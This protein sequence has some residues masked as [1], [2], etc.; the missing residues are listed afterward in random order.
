[1]DE[2]FTI[3]IIDNNEFRKVTDWAKLE[4]FAPGYDDISIFKNTDNQGIWVG[5][6]K[7]EPIGSIACV[8]YNSSYAFIGLF[9]VKKEFRNKGYG[10]SLWKHALNYLKGVDCIGLEAAP[11]RLQDY[12]SWGFKKSSQTNRWKLTGYK[13][14]L[15]ENFYKDIQHEFNV[16]PGD[17]I[18]SEAVLN[19]DSQREPSPRPHFLNDWLS[20]SFGIVNALVDKNGMCH[21]FGRIRPCILEDNKKGWRIGPLLADTPPLA[22]LLIRRLVRDLDCDI[23]LDCSSLN[24]YANYL[25]S[26]LGFVEVSRTYRMYKGMQP[27][28]PMNQVYGLACLELG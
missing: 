4:G 21:G 11:N 1:M 22:E 13:T 2:N 6:L 18:S 3:R 28:F 7:G 12:Q 24:P 20:N 23:L 16:V 10:I 17:Q 15:K 25:L 5:C 9:I 26:N 19:Y 14:L 8:R 27:P